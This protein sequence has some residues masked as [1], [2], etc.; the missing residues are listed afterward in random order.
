VRFMLVGVVNTLFGYGFFYLFLRLGLH[1]AIA[2]FF[3][4]VLGVLFNFKTIGALVFKS[5][6]NQRVVRF[7]LVYLVV[8]GVNSL[9]V[10]VFIGSGFSPSVAGAFLI[11]PMAI[12]AF[13][14]NRKFVFNYV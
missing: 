1:Y 14:L 6:D 13:I 8:Y 5:H 11:L 3:A 7:F 12:L 2:L 10:K 9:G 4:T